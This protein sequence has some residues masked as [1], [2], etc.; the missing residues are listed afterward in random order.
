MKIESVY[1]FNYSGDV[2]YY[3]SIRDF[4]AE[5]MTYFELALSTPKIRVN[6]EPIKFKLNVEVSAKIREI[7]VNYLDKLNEITE[8]LA[9]NSPKYIMIS[10]VDNTK[11]FYEYNEGFCAIFNLINKYKPKED[12]TKKK[13][14]NSF[15]VESPATNTTRFQTILS[16]SKTNNNYEDEKQTEY[17]KKL[18][19]R[20]RLLIGIIVIIVF[21]VGMAI[22]FIQFDSD[23]D[24]DIVNT[25]EY[26]DE[27]TLKETSFYDT[28]IPMNEPASGTILY[29]DE[30]YDGSEL[31]INTPQ[32]SAC[33]VKLKNRDKE[34]VLSFYV[35]ADDSITVNVPREYLYVYFASGY[36]WYGEEYLFGEETSY[37]MDD[38][39]SNFYSYTSE[40][41]LY[42][43]SN[44][45]FQETPIEADEF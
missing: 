13:I 29:G 24:E 6:A 17:D 14:T 43:V 34:D 35:R 30:V 41:T 12:E 33:V 3:K 15:A 4:R 9:E 1:Y 28:L 19:L 39:I 18:S 25:T 2:G 38:E 22:P 27:E 7:V 31:T 11:L 36:T 16:E 45:N 42:S 20:Y 37:S 32:D 5:E 21:F 10:L 40:Y 26:R 44:G 8:V 23:H